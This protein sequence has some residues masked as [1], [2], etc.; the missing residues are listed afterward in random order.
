MIEA[1][2]T[3]EQVDALNRWQTR[4]DVHPFTCPNRTNGVHKARAER[5]GDLG[6]LLATPEGWICGDCDYTQF[7][8]H[9]FML[10]D[11]PNALDEIFRSKTPFP[12]K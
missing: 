6:A 2:F 3:Y 1:P 9:E 5:G 10:T 8:A 11:P 12:P 4:G 7:W